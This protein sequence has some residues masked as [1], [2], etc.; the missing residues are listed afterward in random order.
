MYI[1]HNGFKMIVLE[2][3][4]YKTI[5]AI[6]VPIAM[7]SFISFMVNLLDTL[8]LGQLG[9]NSLSGATLAGQM[10]FILTLAIAGV[11]EGS[12]VL[13][14]QYYGKGDYN[15]IHKIYAIA[16]R[17]A[18]FF[19]VIASVTAFLIPEVF[20]NIYSNEPEVIEEGTK[21]LRIMALS[22]IPF[23]ITTCTTTTLRS[24]H[25]TKIAVVVYGTSFFIN[26]FLNYGLIFGNF[27]MPRLEIIGAGIATVIARSVELIIIIVY[28]CKFDQKI[29]LKFAH[30]KTVDRLI[31]KNFLK[32]STPI[33]VNEI[34]WVM[35]TTTMSI[36]FGRMGKSMVSANA[37]SMVMF[38]LVSIF[39]FGIASA[40]LVIIGNVIGEGKIT[41]A[42]KYANT[43]VVIA[44]LMGVIS[45]ATVYF[46]KDFVISFYNI[47]KETEIIAKEI[48]TANSVI[49]FFQSLSIIC[50]MGILRGG[51]DSKFVLY[52]EI[53]FLWFL[54]VPLGI[55][56]AF[57]LDAPV[58]L[59]YCCTKIDEIFKSI[60]FVVRIIKGKW[61]KDTTIYAST[62]NPQPVEK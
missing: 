41:K 32:N 44:I 9:E 61:A 48:L 5:L 39:L 30:L 45:S 16:Y 1:I 42:Y 56:S 14:S 37:I 21:Y 34:M 40:S 47:T 36:I 18:I 4:F 33:L 53:T 7:Q 15:S 51:G 10:F 29:K 57:Y 11:S 31:F 20:M 58:F 2:K 55:L 62:K 50:G 28:M 3:K 59:V 54:A 17:G 24:V 25:S 49:L 52:S 38:Q 8:M 43:F 23:S 26:A 12:N 6:G 22:Y 19:G 35:G 60:F 27:G 46:S 13:L